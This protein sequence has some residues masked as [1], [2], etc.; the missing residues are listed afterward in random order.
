MA[1]PTRVGPRGHRTTNGANGIPIRPVHG[2]HWSV[3]IGVSSCGTHFG[4]TASL[5]LG[6]VCR[7][8]R[9]PPKSSA[10][11]D[12]AVV[13]SRPVSI[14]LRVLTGFF[15][16]C[17][18]VRANKRRPGINAASRSAQPWFTTPR[19]ILAISNGCLRIARHRARYAA[20]GS[21]RAA[22]TPA[23]PPVFTAASNPDPVNG[24][25]KE[26]ASPAG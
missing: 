13:V 12:L 19:R 20:I 17:G 11:Y 16:W 23:I 2:S 8:P 14:F 6:E 7:L 21:W 15:H 24:S 1:S 22:A 10:R 9:W 3:N 4:S 5:S 18:R 25:T 26:S